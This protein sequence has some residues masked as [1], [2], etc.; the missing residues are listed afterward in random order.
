MQYLLTQEELNSLVS[1]D[2][3]KRKCKDIE[4]L[5]KL[6]LKLADFKCIHDRT[7]EDED[8]YGYEFYCDDCPLARTGTCDRT[9]DFSQ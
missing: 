9:Q 7:K 5:N 1:A 3:Y 8:K 6:A 2:K 4:K